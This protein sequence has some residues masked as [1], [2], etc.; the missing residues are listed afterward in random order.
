LWFVSQVEA[1]RPVLVGK[2]G[3]PTENGSKNTMISR[4]FLAAIGDF[5]AGSYRKSLEPA[6]EIIDLDNL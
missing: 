5:S 4:G 1:Y 6:F 2:L 3:K